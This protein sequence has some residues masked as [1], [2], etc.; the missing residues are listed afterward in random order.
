VK[1]VGVVKAA[2]GFLVAFR[3]LWIPSYTPRQIT[4]DPKAAA[5]ANATNSSAAGMLF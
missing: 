3:Y 4:V 5:A 2:A 1:A